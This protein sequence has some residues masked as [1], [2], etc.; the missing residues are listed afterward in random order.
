MLLILKRFFFSRKCVF[1]IT[2]WL[3]FLTEVNLI[4]MWGYFQTADSFYLF[5][6]AALI[7]LYLVD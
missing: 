1:L 6:K 4:P 7:H 2:E 5:I 3:L